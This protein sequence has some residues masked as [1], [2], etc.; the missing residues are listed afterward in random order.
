MALPLWLTFSQACLLGNLTT[1]L[2]PFSC[3]AM[4]GG[5]LLVLASPP[6]TLV[7]FCAFLPQFLEPGRPIFGQFAAM[8]LSG[9]LIVCL[10]H[11]FYCFTAWRFGLRLKASPLAA[12]FKRAT[13]ALFIGLGVRLVNTRAV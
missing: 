11:S 2:L 6:K 3:V 9:A 1:Q 10:V 8:Y 13:G 5:A 7:F 12:W 4:G